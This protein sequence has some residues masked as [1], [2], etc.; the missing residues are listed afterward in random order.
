ME[1]PLI[2]LL[3]LTMLSVTY[4]GL[5]GAII[6]LL[7]VLLGSLTFFLFKKRKHPNLTR[8]T[9]AKRREIREREQ[10]IPAFECKKS[11]PYC[12]YN[13]NVEYHHAPKTTY[14][15]AARSR[16]TQN[17]QHFTKCLLP[18]KVER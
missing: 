12:G 14:Q 13:G 5:I 1:L 6:F 15:L 18:K 11:D 4:L 3:Q 10:E 2:H 17:L 7:V 9:A 8:Q 16:L